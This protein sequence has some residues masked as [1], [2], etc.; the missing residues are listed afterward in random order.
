ME[1]KE[2]DRWCSSATLLIRFGPDREEV[3]KEL[4]SHM[5]DH[6]DALTEKGFSHE[7]ATEQV[8]ATMGD[9]RE[10]SRQLAAVHRPFWAYFLRCSRI[11]VAIALFLCICSVLHY[12]SGLRFGVRNYLDFDVY[13]AASYGGDTGR[14]L[15][16]LSQP[17]CAFSSDGNTFTLTD[18]AVF[19]DTHNG[20]ERTRFFFRIEQFSWIPWSVQDDYFGFFP[21][22]NNMGSF[23]YAVDSLGNRYDSF[24]ERNGEK[25]NINPAGGQT[26]VFT[27]THECWING[28]SADAEWV[29]ICYTRDGRDLRLKI[30]LEG[31]VGE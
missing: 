4:R 1:N 27:Y 22:T 21:D 25:P 11:A 20:T 19:S 16:H 3:A 24:Q 23:L 31:G 12:F 26:G 5:E 29:E 6:Y 30:M 10:I 2:F 8:I 7:E 9:D 13:D 15:L 14:T 17:G 18:A 28:F